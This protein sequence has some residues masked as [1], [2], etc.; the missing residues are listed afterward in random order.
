MN[1]DVVSVAWVVK[2]THVK[3]FAHVLWHWVPGANVAAQ[4]GFAAQEKQACDVL[5]LTPQPL[6]PKP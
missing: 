4:G 3:A 6:N 2:Q 5:P 1:H